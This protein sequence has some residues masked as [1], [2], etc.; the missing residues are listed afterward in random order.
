[1]KKNAQLSFEE[2]LARLEEIVRK[3]EAG[4][5]PLDESIALYDE[6]MRLAR[7]CSEKL[8][9]AELRVSMLTSNGTLKDVSVEELGAEEDS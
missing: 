6:G 8:D 1:M 7:L 9:A 4:N 5:L 2:A 3:L